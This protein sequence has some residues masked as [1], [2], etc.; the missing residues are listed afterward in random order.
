V[1]L[2]QLNAPERV[3]QRRH[4]QALGRYPV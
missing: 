1:F 2:L 4:L 3:R